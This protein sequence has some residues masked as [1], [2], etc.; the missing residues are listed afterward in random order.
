MIAVAVAAAAAL[1]A[2]GD[3]PVQVVFKGN[4]KA[5]PDDRGCVSWWGPT[6]LHTNSNTT[7][8]C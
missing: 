4:P 2:A 7:I 1:S 5:K 6:F 3:L 8:I